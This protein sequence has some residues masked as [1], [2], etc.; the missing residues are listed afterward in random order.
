[1]E[2]LK[3][4]LACVAAANFYGI[5]PDQFTARICVEYFAVLIPSSS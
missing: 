4:V 3:I 1:M 2:S 5:V